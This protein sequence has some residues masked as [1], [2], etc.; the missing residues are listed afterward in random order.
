MEGRRHALAKI[1]KTVDAMMQTNKRSVETQTDQSTRDKYG[2]SAY[3]A[4]RADRRTSGPDGVDSQ[5]VSAADIAANGGNKGRGK[6]KH[7]ASAA[8][9]GLTSVLDRPPTKKLT[10]GMKKLAELQSN[11]QKEAQAE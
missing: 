1:Q 6:Q 10:A 4:D 3:N 2:D 5:A 9:S 11:I 7:M 8:G